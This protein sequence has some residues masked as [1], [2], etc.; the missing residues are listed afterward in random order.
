[1]LIARLGK[2]AAHCLHG[3]GMQAQI[4]SAAGGQLDQIERR[5]PAAVRPALAPAF[6]FALGRNAAVPHLVAG[7]GKAIEPPVTRPNPVFERQHRHPGCQNAT[8]TMQPL[9]R[10]LP[11]LND[12]VSALENLDDRFCRELPADRC[13]FRS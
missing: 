12:R 11:V 3:I 6:R 1:M 4:G 9:M 13:P 2:L 8:R 5:W 10:F 7:N